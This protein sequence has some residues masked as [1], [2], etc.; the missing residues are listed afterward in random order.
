METK[1]KY[2]GKWLRVSFPVLLIT[3]LI[4]S[5]LISEPVEPEETEQIQETAQ[6]V[7][8]SFDDSDF[9]DEFQTRI[10]VRRPE[11][12]LI[13]RTETDE[14][15]FSLNFIRQRFIQSNRQLY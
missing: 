6:T 3:L 1:K 2:L 10:Q 9:D 12:D 8:G 7:Q 4:A 14:I 15:R 13:P 5:S 11:R